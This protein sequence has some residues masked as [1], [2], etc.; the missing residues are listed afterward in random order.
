MYTVLYLFCNLDRYIARI[1]WISCAILTCFIVLRISIGWN[2]FKMW[3][4]CASIILLYTTE[5]VRSEMLTYQKRLKANYTR[6]MRLTSQLKSTNKRHEFKKYLHKWK[7]QETHIDEKVRQ[8][9]PILSL[10]SLSLIINLCL[11]LIRSIQ[12]PNYL[13][14]LSY[15]G[16]D[17]NNEYSH[18]YIFQFDI[19][20]ERLYGII[21]V[22][23][24]NYLHL[25]DWS[26]NIDTIEE[27][28]QNDD[29]QV[30]NEDHAMPVVARYYRSKLEKNQYSQN[31]SVTRMTTVVSSDERKD[32]VSPLP[33]DLS[34][35][36]N[37]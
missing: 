20:M 4:Q 15:H 12:D 30:V 32:I 29:K 34:L 14:R 21:C 22:L 25:S 28:N 18:M 8:I 5:F 10:I 13:V 3:R 1:Q 37:E 36:T 16:Y 26:R 7:Q 19:Y 17:V 24:V 9:R 31:T 33:N 6:G 11:I 23:P 35:Q 2:A 27:L